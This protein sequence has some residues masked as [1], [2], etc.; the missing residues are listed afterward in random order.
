MGMCIPD[1]CQHVYVHFGKTHRG[2][3]IRLFLA[4][5]AS[6]LASDFLVLCDAQLPAVSGSAPA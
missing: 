3:C 2:E 5:S 1:V 6:A 4:T